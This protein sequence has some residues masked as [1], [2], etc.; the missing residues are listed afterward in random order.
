M[1]KLKESRQSRKSPSAESNS[2][3]S[4]KNGTTTTNWSQTTTASPSINEKGNNDTKQR[5]L[6]SFDS[7]RQQQRQSSYRLDSNRNEEKPSFDRKSSTC[8]SSSSSSSVAVQKY[9]SKKYTTPYFTLVPY[10]FLF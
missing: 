7:I 4:M 10:V 8:S 9:P 1:S 2:S 5:K 3:G 6:P